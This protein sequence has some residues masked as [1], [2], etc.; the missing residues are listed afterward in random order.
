MT[1]SRDDHTGRRLVHASLVLGSGAVLLAG[2]PWLSLLSPWGYVPP[3]DRPPIESGV[4]SQVFVYG[5]L[6]WRWR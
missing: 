4:T 3:A 6:R 2:W 5:T 1:R